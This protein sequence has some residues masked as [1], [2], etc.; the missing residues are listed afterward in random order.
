MASN[1]VGGDWVK[2]PQW[3]SG[4]SNSGDA[5]KKYGNAGTKRGG[6]N[7][8]PIRRNGNA[9]CMISQQAV[10]NKKAY[11]ESVLNGTRPIL[12]V[13]SGLSKKG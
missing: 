2:A 1:W 3:G 6:F 12:F 13:R 11:A 7:P 5:R 8:N 4:K 9:L 10:A